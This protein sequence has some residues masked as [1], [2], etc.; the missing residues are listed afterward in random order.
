ME[1]L[2][3]GREV[4]GG[5]RG[6]QKEKLAIHLPSC[7]FCSPFCP[8]PTFANTNGGLGAPLNTKENPN[9]EPQPHV[10]LPPATR[11]GRECVWCAGRREQGCS[12]FIKGHRNLGEGHLSRRKNQKGVRRSSKI[13]LAGF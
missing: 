2:R 1:A 9:G 7:C 12:P 6:E 10:W 3:E 4:R 13:K 5:V 8:S 11:S